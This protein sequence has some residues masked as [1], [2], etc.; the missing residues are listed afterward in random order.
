MTRA[1]H[2]GVKFYRGSASAAR[3]YVEADHS[4]SDDYYP[5]EGTGLAEHYI[6]GPGAVWQVG[7]LDGAAYERWVAGY[8]VLTGAGKG[9]AARRRTRVA[10]RRGRHQWTEVPVAGSGT[11]SRHRGGVRLGD[12]S[13]GW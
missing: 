10:V 8:D 3:S 1:M 9:R 13:G 12:A 5:A 4:R 7:D 11:P 6:A 2:G